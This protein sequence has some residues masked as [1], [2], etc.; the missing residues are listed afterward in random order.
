MVGLL[1]IYNL[2]YH[3]EVGL[4][5]DFINYIILYILLASPVVKSSQQTAKEVI[6]PMGMTMTQK[7]LAK[8]AGLDKVEA[9]QLIE[10]KL[11]LVLGNEDR[12]S[13]V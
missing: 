5:K 11:D 13:V 1:S 12:K 4:S 3:R 7:I 6:Y 8:A 2:F 10:A 9:G